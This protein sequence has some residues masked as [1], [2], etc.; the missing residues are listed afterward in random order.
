MRVTC[1]EVYILDI[2]LSVIV[3]IKYIDLY[4]G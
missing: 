1:L 3:R 4:Y 2:F